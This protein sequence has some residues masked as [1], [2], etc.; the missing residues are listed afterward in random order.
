MDLLRFGLYF[1]V[2]SKVLN[3]VMYLEGC[4]KSTGWARNTVTFG[5]RTGKQYILGPP[6]FVVRIFSC[7]EQNQLGKYIGIRS[8][9]AIRFFYHP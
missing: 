7:P 1:V 4:A 3:I 2:S 8:T 5:V 9:Q 6:G